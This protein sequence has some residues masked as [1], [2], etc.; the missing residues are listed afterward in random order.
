MVF[1]V[2]VCLGFVRLFEGIKQ[3]HFACNIKMPAGYSVIVRVPSL[4][5]ALGSSFCSKRSRKVELDQVRIVSF[6][7][8]SFSKI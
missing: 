2:F 8:F 1:C 7:N 6:L 3:S 5:S 4:Q